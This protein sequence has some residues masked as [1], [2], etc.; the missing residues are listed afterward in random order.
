[1]ERVRDWEP[2]AQETEQGVQRLQEE[3]LQ[4]TGQAKLLQDVE[5]ERLAHTIPP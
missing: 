4:S 2:E 3:N 5:N 1:M